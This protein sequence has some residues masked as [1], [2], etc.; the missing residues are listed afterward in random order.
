M[1]E[2]YP[3]ITK[4]AMVRWRW[5]VDAC[6]A[7]LSRLSTWTSLWLLIHLS[8]HSLLSILATVFFAWNMRE[9]SG[10]SA[11]SPRWVD[12]RKFIVKYI[13]RILLSIRT[14]PNVPLVVVFSAR[15]SPPLCRSDYTGW[16]MKQRNRT[17]LVRFELRTLIRKATARIYADSL[18]LRMY[19]SLISFIGIAGRRKPIKL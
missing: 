18:G 9:T 15:A 12:D 17:P 7:H 10:G 6:D 16:S 14:K 4:L 8:N 13:C 11:C 1:Q 3:Q 5:P 2:A 19:Y